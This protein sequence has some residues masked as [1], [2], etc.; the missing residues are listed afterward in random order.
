MRKFFESLE[1]PQ[2]LPY[3]LYLKSCL[4]IEES[5][6]GKGLAINYRI[7]RNA[8]EEAGAAKYLK[9]LKLRQNMHHEL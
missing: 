8:G 3:F 4:E 1:Q 6:V 7:E 9:L 2:R 5:M